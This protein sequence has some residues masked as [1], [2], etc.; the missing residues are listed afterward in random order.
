MS[1]LAP[2]ATLGTSGAEITQAISMT[3]T[4]WRF[5]VISVD[6]HPAD[7]TYPDDREYIMT[8]YGETQVYVGFKSTYAL[9]YDAQ[10]ITFS[11]P[12]NSN[13]GLLFEFAADFSSHV[14]TDNL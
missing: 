4:K 6:H 2:I 14:Y 3:I 11:E 13:V 1:Y 7:N 5:F 12:S 9:V 8:Y 10:P